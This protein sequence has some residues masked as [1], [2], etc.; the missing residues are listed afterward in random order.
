MVCK[1][2]YFINHLITKV[3]MNLI[4]LVSVRPLE[5]TS[6]LRCGESNKTEKYDII[7]A[8]LPD[9]IS[10]VPDYTLLQSTILLYGR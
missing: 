5:G 8:I 2:L 1:G 10:Y 6:K 4:S 9:A 7:V 3:E